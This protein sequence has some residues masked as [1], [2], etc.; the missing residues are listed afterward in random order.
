MAGPYNFAVQS[1]TL[2][3]LLF[4]FNAQAAWNTAL[5]DA[6]LAYRPRFD[7]S[8]IIEQTI[9]RR[10]DLEY[11]GKGSY[12]ATNGQITSYDTKLNAFKT[13]LTPELAGYIPAFLMGA[14]TVTG[15]AAPYSHEMTFDQAT[16]EAV[17]TTIYAEDTEDV[18][19]KCADMCINDATITIGDI[20]AVM[21][22]MNMMGTGRLALGALGSAVPASPDETYLLNSDA[23]LTWGP[24][25]APVPYIG[26]HMSTTLKL[27][28]QLVVHKAP[29]GGLYGL[30]V[31][32]GNPKFS[33]QSTFA[34]KETDDVYTL[35]ANNTACSYS[36][37][38]NSG[39]QAQL[40]IDVPKV[41][42]KATKLGFDGDMVIWQVDVDESTCYQAAGTAPVTL[43]A[44][45]AVASYLATA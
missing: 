4:G 36:L 34:A 9:A 35:F 22:E 30:F 38:I 27:D 44:V 11:A 21:V 8:T 25:G 37:V 39:A 28:N 41:Q 14:D 33:I 40:T 12:F 19:Y 17:P 7:G 1:K 45:N 29:G 31:R 15:A 3:N 32:K 26:R 42:L 10:S 43:T 13:E 6:A 16:R 18:K 2:R 5:A 20:G 24:V 23:V